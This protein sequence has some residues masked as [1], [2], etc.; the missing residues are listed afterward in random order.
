ME[1]ALWDRYACGG[2]P[3]AAS[4]MVAYSFWV[5]VRFSRL[6][7]SGIF[8][9]AISAAL[10]IGFLLSNFPWFQTRST[11]VSVTSVPSFQ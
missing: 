10:A 7:L 5:N 6:W 11:A 4:V 1:S 2:L 3:P 9:S 8:L